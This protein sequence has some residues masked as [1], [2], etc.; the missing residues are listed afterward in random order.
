MQALR[1]D[2]DAQFRVELL[3]HLCDD[4][5]PALA[6]SAA[7]SRGLGHGGGLVAEEFGDEVGEPL[8]GCGS[9]WYTGSHGDSSVR[10]GVTARGLGTCF[11]ERLFSA[12]LYARYY[13]KNGMESQEKYSTFGM[14]MLHFGQEEYYDESWYENSPTA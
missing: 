10:R 14:H 8:A 9:L 7:V 2:L 12:L 5:L 1:E 4:I 6:G 11:P 3:A 13:P